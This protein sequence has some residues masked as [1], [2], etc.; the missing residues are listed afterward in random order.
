MKYVGIQTQIRRNNIM[1]AL[2]L[3]AFPVIILA[4]IWTF[5]A[6]LNYLE[7]SYYDANGNVVY[8]LD[9]ETVN[10]YF[11]QAIPWV[12]IVVGIWFVIAYFSNVS[13][14]R[15]ATGARPLTRR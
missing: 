10:A 8:V 14:I 1:S 2:L 4:M 9:V 7:G 3:L 12:L 15:H 5:L 6:L 13:M 11:V